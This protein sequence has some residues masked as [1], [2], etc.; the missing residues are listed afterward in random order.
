MLTRLPLVQITLPQINPVDIA[1]R[2][3]SALMFEA[4]DHSHREQSELSKILAAMSGLSEEHRRVLTLRK[5]YGWEYERIAAHLG[6][7]PR[8]VEDD[9]CACVQF[10]AQACDSATVETRSTQLRAVPKASP[11]RALAELLPR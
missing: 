5:I 7:D 9:L 6:L 4:R 2:Q 10:L 11:G 1:M 3:K 8:V